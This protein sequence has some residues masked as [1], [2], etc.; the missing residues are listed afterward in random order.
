MAGTG[1][2]D[3]RRRLFLGL[4]AGFITLI[5][6]LGI[7]FIAVNLFSYVCAVNPTTSESWGCRA[8]SVYWP[9]VLFVILM[10]WIGGLGLVSVFLLG[11]SQDTP[12]ILGDSDDTDFWK[13][14]R[15]ID[16][17]ARKAELVE[18]IRKAKSR[19]V[20]NDD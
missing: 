16:D 1:E 9:P 17:E 3:R 14:W 6:G 2:P 18:E 19:I 20:G 7:T 12:P 5:V 10:A 4:L 8:G 11:T 13:W 15:S